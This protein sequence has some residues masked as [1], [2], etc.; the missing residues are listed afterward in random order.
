[1]IAVHLAQLQAEPELLTVDLGEG[2]NSTPCRG[3]Y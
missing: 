1:M 3:R 2:K